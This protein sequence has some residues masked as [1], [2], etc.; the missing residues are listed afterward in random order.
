MSKS[1]PVFEHNTCKGCGGFGRH[2]PVLCK[3]CGGSGY[4]LTKRGFLA[5][6]YLRSLR[7]DPI[8][9][10]AKAANLELALAYQATLM[11]SG[12]QRGTPA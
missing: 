2:G 9:D 3:G 1:T 10:E 4:Q 11:R 8:T 5:A 6:Q 7:T 12:T